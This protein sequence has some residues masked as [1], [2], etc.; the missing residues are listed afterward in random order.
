VTGQVATVIY[1][2]LGIPLIF[3][4]FAYLG[5]KLMDVIGFRIA[6]HAFPASASHPKRG[7]VSFGPHSAVWAGSL[8]EGT[9]FKRKQLQEDSILLPFVVANILTVVLICAYAA[10]YF[11]L[12]VLAAGPVL[13]L[14]W[15]GRLDLALACAAAGWT[16]GPIGNPAIS[17]LLPWQPLALATWC[18]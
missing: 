3:Y 7:L 2:T 4:I 6:R 17:S 13:R 16:A 10:I 12:C 9:E 5:R 15:C 11:E 14:A 18:R 8:R 1:A